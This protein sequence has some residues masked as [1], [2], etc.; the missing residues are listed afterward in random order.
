MCAERITLNAVDEKLAFI[1]SYFGSPKFDYRS[2]YSLFVMDEVYR[3]VL[4]FSKQIV[5]TCIQQTRNYSFYNHSSLVHVL[6]VKPY[7]VNIPI[8][9][10]LNSVAFSPQANYTDRATAACWRS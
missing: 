7:M 10:S 8:S 5:E 2:L 9:S 1:L 6:R 4:H 3:N